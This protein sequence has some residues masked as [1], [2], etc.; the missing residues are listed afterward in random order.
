[1]PRLTLL[2]WLLVAALC[3]I[4]I[5][6]AVAVIPVQ[7]VVASS[8]GDI[9]R[10]ALNTGYGATLLLVVDTCEGNE[11]SAMHNRTYPDGSTKTE[12]PPNGCFSGPA[13]DESEI[14][15]VMKQSEAEKAT[16]FSSI[17]SLTADRR[18]EERRVGKECR[19]RWSPYH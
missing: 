13:A 8:N 17:T 6:S 10:C 4:G 5:A 16:K 9:F 1:M 19:S 11:F 14:P 2:I 18:S 7:N 15:A 12:I 3:S